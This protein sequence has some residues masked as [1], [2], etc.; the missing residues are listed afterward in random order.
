MTVTNGSGH[1]VE[2]GGAKDA[3][4][5]FVRLTPEGHTQQWLTFYQNPAN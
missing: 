3:Q 5:N 4:A 2:E 1:G